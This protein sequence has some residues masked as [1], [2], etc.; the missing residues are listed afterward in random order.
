MQAEIIYVNARCAALEIKDGGI[1]ETE[2]PYELYLDG[3]F[4]MTSSLVI[5]M[6][7]E[8]VP[9]HTYKLSVRSET[10]ETELSF[11]TSYE[12]VTLNVRD[13]G[14]R[15]DGLSDDTP[16]IQAAVMAAPAHSR[17]LIP[18]GTYQIASLFLKDGLNLELGRGAVLKAFT[19]RGRYPVFPGTLRGNRDGEEMVLGTWEGDSA[20]MFTGI[21]CGVEIRHAV[22]YGQ[23]T[24][25]GCAGK[26]NWWDRPKEIRTA[27]R[28]RMVF[29]NRCEHITILGITVK[30][31]PSWNIHPYF[32]KHLRFLGLRILG[33]SD[34]PN[35]DG[36]DPEA[37]SDVEIAGVYFS[38]GDDCIAVKSGKKEIGARYKVPSE[39]ILIRQCC[40]RDGHGA[41]TLG[42]E[43]AAGVKNLR[44]LDCCFL[45]TDRGLRIKTRRGRGRDAVIDNIL[46]QNIRMDHVMTPFVINSFYSCDPDG[47]T[48]Y[49]QCREALPVDDGTPSVKK[50]V[51]RDIHADNCH[52]AAAFFYG[53]P[54]QKISFVEMERVEINF[55]DNAKS[56]LPA[57]MDG[58]GPDISKMSIFAANIEKLV[59]K[60]VSIT[61]Q[62][63]EELHTE[64]VDAVIR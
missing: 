35:T 3:E 63:G 45:H 38:V 59:L 57:M 26:D 49:V 5:T 27:A 41:V 42:S 8:L 21:L 61:G 44:A 6:L 2:Q 11:T 30:N 54:E 9:E 47:H 33:P 60:D 39:D 51:F 14:A 58:I 64:H 36:L 52:V 1:F 24:L 37:C 18:E 48:A 31:S 50:L 23:G 40:M 56:G 13:F 22:V 19:E 28:P 16:Y 25:D 62:S 53:L 55:A 4:Y 17:V 43:M 34:S 32:S 20:P 29:L 15:G 10:V 46:F 7:Y 12:F